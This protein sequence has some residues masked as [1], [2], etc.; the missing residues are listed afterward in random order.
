MLKYAKHFIAIC[1]TIVMIACVF[2]ATM[3]SVGAQES[4][5]SN[6]VFSISSVIGQPGDIIEIDISVLGNAEVSGL[7]LYGLQYNTSAL[8]FIAFRDYGELVTESITGEN[9]VSESV[10]NLGYSPKIVPNGKICT[11]VFRIKDDAEEG[12][13][14]IQFAQAAASNNGTPVPNTLNEGILTVFTWLPGDFDENGIVDMQDVVHFMGWVNFSYIPG[15]YPMVYD[16][17]KDFDHNGT[18]DM[19]DVVYFM[20]WVNFSYIPGLYEIDWDLSWDYKMET[21]IIE[22]QPSDDEDV[23]AVSQHV[24]GNYRVKPAQ[25][26]ITG[27]LPSISGYD[28]NYY[29]WIWYLGDLESV[30]LQSNQDFGAGTSVYYDGTKDFTYEFSYT[31]STADSVE[32]AL[33]TASS[34][35]T[36]WTTTSEITVSNSTEFDLGFIKDTLEVG[37]TQT[38]GES[39][40]NTETI[41]QSISNTASKTVTA[42][43]AI[44]TYFDKNCEAGYY[45]W[46]LIGDVEVYACIIY[47]RQEN[48]VVFCDNI[49]KVVGSPGYG[50]EY[51][52][53]S[54]FDLDRY[55]TL[56]FDCPTIETLLSNYRPTAE[57]SIYQTPIQE[58]VPTSDIRISLTK[59]SCKVN[60][61]YDPSKTG[62]ST[63]EKLH[64]QF[65]MFNLTLSGCL[66]NAD[67]TYTVQEKNKF[68]LTLNLLQ[69]P[70]SLP[71]GIGKALGWWSFNDYYVTNDSYFGSVCDVDP[72]Y[73]I[74]F[75]DNIGKGAFCATIYLK[76]GAKITLMRNNFIQGMT[77]GDSL[78]LITEMENVDPGSVDRIEIVVVYEL[79]YK[80]YSNLWWYSGYT[81]YRC[82]QTIYFD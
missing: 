13:Y 55:D 18:I 9:S 51:S 38:W 62:G 19:Q 45:R 26:S 8:E 6:V 39:N 73:Q 27:E 10:I 66:Y 22:N 42:S 50:F 46:G 32:K 58:A 56:P 74:D 61:G 63:A 70:K 47:D 3:F 80:Q 57:I 7:L 53:N 52:Q 14:S 29:Y 59:E 16:G 68:N 44:S 76:S 60:N 11:A 77:K 24:S 79:M 40:S 48:I 67:G 28:D 31:Q 21:E 49:E 5:S 15:L 30:P 25:P 81:N 64:S 34:K 36:V 12:K 1:L 23:L 69:N 17:D 41:T 43:T 72:N 75:K 65:D 78:S 71:R 4:E 82:T 20:G 54:K 37:Y 2:P 35:T 33:S